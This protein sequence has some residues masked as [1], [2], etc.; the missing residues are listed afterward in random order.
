YV[1]RLPL[2][3]GHD[4]T[5]H[6]GPATRDFRMSEEGGALLVN[7][8]RLFI[9]RT[10]LTGWRERENAAATFRNGNEFRPFLVAWG[11]TETY[12]VD[13]TIASLGYAASKSYGIS[14]SQYSPSLVR[15]MDRDNPTG[16]LIDSVF[17]DNW[18]GFYC[19]EA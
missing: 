7:D 8:G 2:V 6:L 10:R 3:V 9:I 17:E 14:L 15:A 18:Y 11:G 19:Y 1:L 4:A 13:S 12:I 16:W 5:L